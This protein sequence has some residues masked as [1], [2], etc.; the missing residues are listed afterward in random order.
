MNK[1]IGIIGLG[2]C[3]MPAAKQFI[4]KGYTVYGYARRPEVIAEFEG[5]GGRYVKSPMEV[6]RHAPAVIVMVL[7]DGQVI[8]VISGEKG[9]LK[10]AGPGST[11]ICMSTINRDNLT[12]MDSACRAKGVHLID[13]PFTGGPARVEKGTLTLIVAAPQEILEPL[14]PTLEV[15]GQITYAGSVPGMGQAVKHCNQLLVTTIHAATVE[16]IMLA[17]KTGVD[18]K[19]VCDVVGSGIGGNDYFRLLSKGIL[20]NASSPGGMGQIWKDVNIVVTSA[21]AHN[22]PLLVATSAAQYF[23]MAISQGMA[24][25]DS[26][27][28]MEVLEGMTGK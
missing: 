5:F 15:L 2:R 10:A 6:A 25:E 3:G 19:L 28:L 4:N 9:V 8:E 27:K 18:P 11:V 1:T 22:L 26:A 7:D 23:N 16:L 14:R 20:E 12:A 17:R 21:R 24:N 13:S